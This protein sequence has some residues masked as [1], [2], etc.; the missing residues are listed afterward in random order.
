MTF[1]LL[2]D[3]DAIDEDAEDLHLPRVDAA[4]VGD[5]LD[6][7]DDD[8]AGIAAAIAIASAW[9]VSASRSIVMLPSGSAVV[10]RMIPTWIGN[11][12]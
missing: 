12:R 8:A 1:R 4:A 3:D 9:S 6:L 5:P 2:G 11:A 10:P 7:R